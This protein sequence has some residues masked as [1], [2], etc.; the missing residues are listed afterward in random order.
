MPSR[1]F[2]KNY[3]QNQALSSEQWQWRP[4]NSGK[5]AS[6]SP[7]AVDL[8][9][10][11]SSA[12]GAGNASEQLLASTESNSNSNELSPSSALNVSKDLHSAVERIQIREPTTEGESCSSLLPY[13]NCNRLA[14]VDQELKVQVPLESCAKEESSSIKSKENNVSNCKGSED[15]NKPSVNLDPFDICPPKSGRITL[16]PSLLATNKEKRNETKRA[17]EGNCGV[18]L[19]PGM[20]LLKSGISLRDQ[21]YINFHSLRLTYINE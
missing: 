1:N 13:D 14:A 5:D 20:V 9:Q 7:G 11:H 17:T 12:D 18:V 2:R 3:G 21:V 15:N 8:Q 19:R 16:N 6:P 4:L 10:E